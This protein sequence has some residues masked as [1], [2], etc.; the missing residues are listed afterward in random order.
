M[1]IIIQGPI[2]RGDASSLILDRVLKTAYLNLSKP[3]LGLWIYLYLNDEGT[4][5]NLQQKEIKE[6][7]NISPSSYHKAIKELQE[8]RFLI[9]REKEPDIFDFYFYSLQKE[10]TA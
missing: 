8:K 7:L 5:I 3:A 4:I 6:Q 9:K 10:G 2:W 1:T